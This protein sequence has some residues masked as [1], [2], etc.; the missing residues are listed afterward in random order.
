MKFE[1]IKVGEFYCEGNARSNYSWSRNRVKVVALHKG[2]KLPSGFRYCP[3]GHYHDQ[4]DLNRMAVCIEK[5]IRT[6]DGQD[7]LAHEVVFP[8]SILMLWTDWEKEVARLETHD[9]EAHRLANE[10]RDDEKRRWAKIAPIL[11]S[12]GISGSFSCV[13]YGGD[14]LTV[15]LSSLEALV[16]DL[17]KEN[18]SVASSVTSKKEG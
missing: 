17:K 16:A 18:S 4:Y 3:R 8:Q 13:D 10:Q 1:D 2:G 11:Q 6:F 14:H 5:P 15:Y 9:K 7:T 12:Y